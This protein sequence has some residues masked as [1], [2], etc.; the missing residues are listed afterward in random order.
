MRKATSSMT[1]GII[2]VSVPMFSMAVGDHHHHNRAL[3]RAASWC[4]GFDSF[5][6]LWAT[7]W[8]PVFVA[9]AVVMPL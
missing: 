5:E 3:V 7:G 4:G 8:L 6:L 2:K 9:V 1:I